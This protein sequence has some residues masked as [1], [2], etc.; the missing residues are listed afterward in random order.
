MDLDLGLRNEFRINDTRN[1]FQI[2]NTWILS[3]MFN[4]KKCADYWLK[5]NGKY[6]ISSMPNE[7]C[8]A[9]EREGLF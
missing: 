3:V 1:E 7:V 9:C 6:K 4:D 2:N 5:S 8:C